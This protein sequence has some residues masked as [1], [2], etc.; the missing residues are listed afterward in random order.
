MEVRSEVA[1]RQTNRQRQ[2]HIV[3]DGGTEMYG[4]CTCSFDNKNVHIAVVEQYAN[5]TD[6]TSDKLC[7]L[8]QTTAGQWNT[9]S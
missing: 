8:Q 4:I 3:L 5:W 2:L 1:K 7:S 6:N 9:Q